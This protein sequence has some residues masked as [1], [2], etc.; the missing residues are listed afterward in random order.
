[1]SF[2]IQTMR[3]FFALMFLITV[4]YVHAQNDAPLK[5]QRIDSLTTKFL[6]DSLHTYR[7]KIVRPY[8]NIDNRNSFLKN[9]AS[10][11]NGYQLGVIFDDYHTFG[12]GFYQL[13][14]ATRLNAPVKSGYQLRNLRYTTIFYEFMLV[15]GKY[16]EMDLPF[17]I[18]YGSYKALFT[19]S[20]DAV[21]NRPVSPSFLPL[22]GGVKFI[23]KPVRWIG[24]S[25]MI[26]YRY[27][28]QEA[29]ILELNNLYFP[30]GIW[31]DLRQVYRDVKFYGFQRK[32]YRRAVRAIRES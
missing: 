12:I 26:G 6:K 11:F 22:A 16:F 30:F 8:G 19:D 18:G 13:N 23:G 31:V 10:N 32:R 2:D 9:R 5:Q 24:V 29:S 20:S 4:I 27:I 17:E 14:R 7:Y 3:L 25:V 28:F 15:N 1:M 21:Y